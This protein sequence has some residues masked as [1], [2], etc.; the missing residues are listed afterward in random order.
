MQGKIVING[1]NKSFVYKDQ[2]LEVLRD[3]DLS[4]NAGEFLCI[5]GHSGCG[6]S[7]LLKCIAGLETD[8]DGEILI[9]GK[10]T[11]YPTLDKGILFQDH[12]LFPWFN[13]VD[14]IGFALLDKTPNKKEK[15]Q[16]LIELVGLNGFEKAYPRQLSGGM[17]QRVAIARALINKPKILLLDE[18]LGALDALT[19]IKM[20]KEILKLWETEKTTTVLVTH[21]IDEAVFL[22]QRIVILSKRP[23]TI[24][25]ITSVDIDYPRN[26]TGKEFMKI[27]DSVYKEFFA[28]D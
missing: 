5:L 14:N 15:V 24:R 1:L 12:R 8:Y 26:R 13:V 28:E 9:D 17:A 25:K 18:P 23:G 21:D 27:R 6:K 3:I 22:G 2:E 4:I 11:K 20:Q 7:T 16:E 19:R 10:E